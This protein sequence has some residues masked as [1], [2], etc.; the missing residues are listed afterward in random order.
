[1]L[2]FEEKTAMNEEY[3][4]ALEKYCSENSF[5][6]INANPYKKDILTVYPDRDY[7]LDH[8]HPNASKGVVLYSEAVLVS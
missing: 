5:M 1:V 4:T 8:I 2:S 6:Y 7:L 3:S